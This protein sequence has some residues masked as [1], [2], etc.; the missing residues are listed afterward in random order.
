MK[1]NSLGLT[2]LLAAFAGS[3]ALAQTHISATLKCPEA[4]FSQPPV[5]VGDQAGH[6]LMVS[7][8][9]CTFSKPAEI[10]GLKMTTNNTAEFTEMTGGKFQ[11]RGYAVV[12]MENGE[13]LYA[14]SQDTGIMKD[15]GIFTD[16]G[17]WTLTGGT[18]ELKGITG[19]GTNKTSGV[20]GRGEEV[21]LEG[22]YSLPG[23]S[24]TPKSK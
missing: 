7:K 16:E 15:G 2:V 13:K 20:V 14:R 23:V 5:E 19:K 21:Q 1:H 10:A 11:D 6:V 24:A 4:V 3:S 12:T 18:G 22:E 17:T 9:S 8:M